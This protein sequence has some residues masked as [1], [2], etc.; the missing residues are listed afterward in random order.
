MAWPTKTDF[1]DGDV[2]TAAQVNNIGTNLNLFNPT[3]ATANQ[4]PLANGL[5]SVAWGSVPAGGMTLIASGTLSGSSVGFTSIPQTYVHLYLA[6]LGMNFNT[7]NNWYLRV[8]SS[9]TGNM[10]RQALI[11]ATGSSTG[12]ASGWQVDGGDWTSSAAYQNLQAQFLNYTDT[13][14]YPTCQWWS[15]RGDTSGQGHMIGNGLSYTART[16][17]S[18]IY[19][20]SASGATFTAGTYALYGVK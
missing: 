8:N 9:S 3:S 12:G 15:T 7:T 6:C 5:G 18:S 13:N 4:V 19:L 2:L 1:V 17:I 10:T 20:I 14:R 16:N 11:N